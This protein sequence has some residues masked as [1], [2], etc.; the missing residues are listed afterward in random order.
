[1]MKQG[2]VVQFKVEVWHYLFVAATA[3]TPA[4][5]TAAKILADVVLYCDKYWS[6]YSDRTLLGNSS[7]MHL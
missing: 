1:M 3:A 7:P 5:D 2:E 6:T 4:L